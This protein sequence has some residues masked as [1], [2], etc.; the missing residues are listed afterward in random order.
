MPLFS[1]QILFFIPPLKILVSKLGLAVQDRWILWPEQGLALQDAV[2]NPGPDRGSEA[3][4][5]GT[6]RWAAWPR[7]SGSFLSRSW[8]PSSLPLPAFCTRAHRGL[9]MAWRLLCPASP[10]PLTTP[11]TF[12][13]PPQLSRSR[14]TSDGPPAHP[15]HGLATQHFLETLSHCSLEAGTPPRL[16]PSIEDLQKSAG[17]SWGTEL[18]TTCRSLK[19]TEEEECKMHP[20][21]SP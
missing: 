13:K 21:G 18:M 6:S 17:G 10:Q 15:G 14:V 16:R 1:S 3:G 9:L 12:R 2:R 5:P 20:S 8:A 4:V 19:G 11:Q 7:S